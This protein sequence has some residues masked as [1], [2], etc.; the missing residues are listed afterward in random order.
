MGCTLGA[1]AGSGKTTEGKYG[2][3]P[4]GSHLGS[5]YWDIPWKRQNHC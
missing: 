1:A 3:G 2:I 5:W 4:Y